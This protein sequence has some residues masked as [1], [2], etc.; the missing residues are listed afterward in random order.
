MAWPA[1]LSSSSLS[2]LLSFFLSPSLTYTTS[3]SLC[4]FVFLTIFLSLSL[5]VSLCLFVSVY[6]LFVCLSVSVYLSHFP[7]T[8]HS[9]ENKQKRV[10]SHTTPIYVCPSVSVFLSHPPTPL[11]FIGKKT[12]VRGSSKTAPHQE[13]P[14]SDCTTSRGST[15]RLHHIK[16][17]HSKTAPHQEGPQ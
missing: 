5:S 15:V 13:G 7:L 10:K 11:L 17:V 4:L 3:L 9:K 12:N 14:Q 1:P 8:I 16:R 6:L 2:V